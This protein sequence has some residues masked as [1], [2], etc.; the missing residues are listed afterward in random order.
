LSTLKPIHNECCP[1][2][3]WLRVVHILAQLWT[4]GVLYWPKMYITRPKMCLGSSK[5]VFGHYKTCLGWA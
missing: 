5:N 2:I 4:I 3:F 1:D